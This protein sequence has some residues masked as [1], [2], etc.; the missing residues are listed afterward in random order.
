[1]IWQL[2]LEQLEKYE[3]AV[4][5]YD[6]ALELEQEDYKVWWKKGQALVGE[7]KYSEAVESYD[8]ALALAV[9][10][11]QPS[12]D[13]YIICREYASLLEKLTKY[14]KSIVMCKKSLGFEPR[15]RASSYLKRQVYKKMYSRRG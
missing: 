1:M 11:E 6:K 5:A 4:N 2:N 7:K 8:K 9:K 14:Q 3:E 12:P 13:R 15:Y 10:L